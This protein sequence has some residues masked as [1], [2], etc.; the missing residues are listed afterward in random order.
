VE[1][2]AAIYLKFGELSAFMRFQ[3]EYVREIDKISAKKE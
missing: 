3:G 2:R 1:P